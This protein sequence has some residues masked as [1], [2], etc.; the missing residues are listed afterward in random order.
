MYTKAHGEKN[1]KLRKQRKIQFVGTL[2]ERVCKAV[3]CALLGVILYLQAPSL[4]K[5]PANYFKR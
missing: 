5:L 4:S 2:E 1:G 3:A